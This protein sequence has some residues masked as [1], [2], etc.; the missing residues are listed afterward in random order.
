MSVMPSIPRPDFG[1]PIPSVERTALPFDA[2]QEPDS[3]IVLHVK[4]LSSSA[5]E[6]LEVAR[7]LKMQLA[8][9][10]VGAKG[11][12]VLVSDEEV[13]TSLTPLAPIVQQVVAE[14][15][16]AL[17]IKPVGTFARTVSR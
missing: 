3:A 17:G 10:R 1:D 13:A 15:M 4:I 14:A 8:E 2:R 6:R 9:Q 16:K 12:V 11:I 7:L 5:N